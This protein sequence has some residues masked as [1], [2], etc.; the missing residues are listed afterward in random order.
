VS[1]FVCEHCTSTGKLSS[2]VLFLSRAQVHRHI[3]ASPACKAAG[4]GSRELYLEARADDVM[5]GVGGAAGPAQ[6]I[7]SSSSD[8]CTNLDAESDVC[9]GRY[10]AGCSDRD[11]HFIAHKGPLCYFCA[12]AF[13]DFY[14]TSGTSHQVIRNKKKNTLYNQDPTP[15][16]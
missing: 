8:S 6:A 12:Q 7:N 11:L 1:P 9:K 2:R 13:R 15:M 10:D 16:A 14:W 4:L 5:A 3:N